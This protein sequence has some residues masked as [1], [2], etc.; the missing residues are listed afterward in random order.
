MKIDSEFIKK[1]FNL[2][3]KIKNKQD[4]IKLSKYEES[5]PM[6]DIY[7]QKI[8]PINKQNI[9]YRLIDSHYRFINNEIYQWIKNLYDKYSKDENLG[10]RFKYNI[11]VIDNYDIDTLI[12]TS[13]KTLYK[14]SPLLGLLVSICKRNSFHP[15]IQHLKPYYTKMELIKLGQNMDIIKS[16]IDPEYLIDQESHYKICKSVSKND[17]S[18]D[19][20]KTHHEY[21][22]K[23]GVVGW[24][25]FYSWTGSFLFNKYL[26][27]LSNNEKKNRQIIGNTIDSNYLNGLVKIVKSIE[28]APELNNNYDIYRFIWDDTFLTELKEGDIF[29]D[30][31]FLSTTRDPFYSPGLNGNFGLV[32]IKITI[33]KN[34]KGVGLFIENFS[35]F[36][37]EE[38]FLLPPYSKLKLISKNNKFKYFH[39]NPEFEKL[40]NR[41][42]EFELID[43]EYSRFYKENTQILSNK[44]IFNP[45]D[46]IIINGTDRFDLIKKFIQSYSIN[47]KINLSITTNNY[48]FN[49]QWFDSSDS[50]SYSKFYWNKIKD[51]FLLSIFDTDGYPYLNIELGKELV[52]NFIN[53]LYFGESQTKFEPQGK[54]GEPQGKVK[55]LAVPKEQESSKNQI[56]QSILDLIYHIGRIFYYKY[57]IIFHNYTD[58][59]VFESNYNN[60][61]KIFLSMKLFNNSIYQYL[62]N[63]KK[64]LDFDSFINYELGYWY[65]DEFFNK[66]IIKDKEDKIPFDITEIKT[67]KDLY[68]ECIEKKFNYL[69]KLNEIID[70]NI[71][72]NNFVKYN[73]YERLVVEGI[74]DSFRLDLEY[75]DENLLDNTF[76]LIFRQPIR[77]L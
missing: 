51:G 46:K 14:Y 30:K 45:I 56:T 29:V 55:S 24:I 10:S 43:I 42:Y 35:L 3:I 1:I 74:N 21:I 48:S 41:K 38:E 19:E 27:N 63:G 32:L 57:A 44:I 12:E 23:S 71:I 25:C 11:D 47:N 33:P 53:Q 62:K 18:F 36:P 16:D 59:N 31:G 15:F 28:Q 13:Y 50:S 70:K 68:I 69:E 39:T 65:L 2:K 64:Y 58:F 22:L 72:K 6:Y 37:K 54:A 75:N 40:I 9:H 34:K 49:Y 7:S 8:Y 26:R 52:V 66:N 60:E 73:I 17:V 5:I 67:N 76:K 4:K 61:Q 77:R 20:I